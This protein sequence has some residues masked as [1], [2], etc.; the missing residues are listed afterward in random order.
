MPLLQKINPSV[1]RVLSRNAEVFRKEH[2]LCRS[3]AED[4][5]DDNAREDNDS[6]RFCPSSLLSAPAGL[7]LAVLRESLRRV[8][9]DLRSVSQVH[10][11]DL[12]ALIKSDKPGAS[13][14]LP[15]VRAYLDKNKVVL[16]RTEKED[17]GV[18][19][20]YR[21]E[22][23]DP[24][25]GLLLEVPGALEWQG[26]G[27]R[28]YHVSAQISEVTGPADLFCEVYLDPSGLRGA[29]RVRRF[30]SGERF[31]PGGRT[32]RKLKKFMNEL[33][34]PWR[35]REVWPLIE[36][37]EG[38]VWVPGLEPAARAR[39]QAGSR[40]LRVRISPSPGEFL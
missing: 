32:K 24:V 14:D 35:D 17:S 20:K 1:A 27:G 26:P 28:S 25:E 9:G 16:Q 40:S 13:L 36:D 29:L 8:K 10:V 33:G 31:H 34:I 21:A 19:R 30:Q 22:R 15:G 37:E 38:L 5:L 23:K 3:L 4:W 18:A 12:L 2:E 11:D 7:C 6:I 39:A